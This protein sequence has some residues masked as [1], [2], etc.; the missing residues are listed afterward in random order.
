MNALQLVLVMVMVMPGPIVAEP[1]D[2]IVVNSA[3]GYQFVKVR[4][5]L[6]EVDRFICEACGRPEPQEQRSNGAALQLFAFEE[7]VG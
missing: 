6:D 7:H 3:D 5:R 2:F 1:G 4:G